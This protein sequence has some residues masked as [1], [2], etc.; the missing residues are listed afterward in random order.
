M[1]RDAIHCSWRRRHQR[2]PTHVV[3]G[4][5][6]AQILFALNPTQNSTLRADARFSILLLDDGADVIGEILDALV[7]RGLVRPQFIPEGAAAAVRATVVVD[8]G[9]VA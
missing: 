8:W 6:S 4:E 3:V 9:I 2:E 5:R 1:Q 7:E